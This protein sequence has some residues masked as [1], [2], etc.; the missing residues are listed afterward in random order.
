MLSLLVLTVY[1]ISEWRVSGMQRQIDEVMS[2]DPSMDA[3]LLEKIQSIQHQ[4]LDF[5]EAEEQEAETWHQNWRNLQDQINMI[6]EDVQTLKTE[7]GD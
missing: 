5:I 4:L 3:P 6:Y 7:R 1:G 2:L